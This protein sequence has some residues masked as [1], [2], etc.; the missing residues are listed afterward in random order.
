MR[1]YKTF[2][3]SSNAINFNNLLKY[4][5]SSDIAILLSSSNI[6]VKRYIQK[7]FPDINFV[8]PQHKNKPTLIY[9]SNLTIEKAVE[10]S[11]DKSIIKYS[12]KI[13]QESFKN[14]DFDLED[15]FYDDKNL[16][17]SWDSIKIPQP[18]LAFLIMKVIVHPKSKIFQNKSY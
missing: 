8:S 12:A 9:H 7:K 13:N 15:K 3:I 10:R 4:F 1:N 17:K 11:H 18:I 6:V 14:V 16:K 2:K 5:K